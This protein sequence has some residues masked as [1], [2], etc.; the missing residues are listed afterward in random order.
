MVVGKKRRTSLPS[1]FLRIINNEINMQTVSTQILSPS[2]SFKLK[3]KRRIISDFETMVRRCEEGGNTPVRAAIY[4]KI[5]LKYHV[6][7]RTIIRYLKE[8]NVI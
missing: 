4:E 2:Q 1:F 8:A 5:G 6:N 3:R 7:P